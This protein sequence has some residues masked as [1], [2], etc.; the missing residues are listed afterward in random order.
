MYFLLFLVYNKIYRG[1]DMLIEF[2]FKNF[3][4]FKNKVT[5]SME[6]GNGDENLDNVSTNNNVDLLKSAAIYG[7]NASGK[8]NVLKALTCAILMVRNSSLIPIGGK[9]NIIK[10]FLFDEASKKKPSEFEF[11]FIANNV[12]YRYYFSADATKIYDEI[13]DAYYSQKPTNIF[14]RTNTNNYVFNSDKSKLET[15]SANNTENKLF[16]TTATTWNYDK[17]KDVYLWFANVIDTYD[18]F[19]SITD[20]DLVDYSNDKENLKEFALKLLKEADILIKDINVDYE[21]VETDNTV[22]DMLVPSLARNGKKFKVKNVNIELEHEV[23]DGNNKKHFYKLNFIE[24]S[25]GTRVLFAIAPFLKRAFETRK[26]IV[27]DELEKS[28]HPTLVEFIVK[29]FNNKDINKA[30]SQLIFTTH[31]INLLNLELLRRDQIW[32]T[33]KN[34]ESGVSDLYSLDSFPVRKDENIQKGYINGRYGAV[35][36]IRDID[37]WLEDN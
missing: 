19:D 7:A 17:T 36:F 4:S 1:D 14:T 11:V 28:M 9:W 26:V 34:P 23:V 2:S 13:L 18:S 20:N 21:E 35:P 31:A 27:V 29:L 12:K 30:N 22:V 37:L 25:S 16:L 24:E 10:P 15:L 6:K 33:E 32:F 3:L 5:L 8:S